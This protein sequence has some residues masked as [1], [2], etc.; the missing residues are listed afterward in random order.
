MFGTANK[1]SKMNFIDRNLSYSWGKFV[2]KPKGTHGPRVNRNLQ[3]VILHSGE[4][5][6]WVNGVER[7]LGPNEAC[8]CLP[9]DREYFE[10]S[11]TEE[12]M[13]SWCQVDGPNLAP[14]DRER[15]A[16]LPAVVQMDEGMGRLLELG[17]ELWSEGEANARD[18]LNRL[19]QTLLVAYLR[20]AGFYD[21][22]EKRSRQS[23][24]LEK[25]ERWI[26]VRLAQPLAVKDIAR[27]AG[28]SPQYLSRLF[29]EACGLTPIKYLWELR[30][31][32]AARLLEE[33]GLGVA[34]IAYRVGFKDPYHFS[35]RFKRRYG[36]TAREFRRELW[37]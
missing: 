31:R 28:L 8:L 32:E 35:K 37:G 16:A 17:L 33:T 30:L 18:L 11:K 21:G 34:E 2:Y 4:V 7:R 24:Y 23:L 15:L 9:G 5:R 36:K 14:G 25:C 29:L 1:L 10:F 27:A 26:R 20:K 13:H 6:V 22:V 12:S 3:L 19:A